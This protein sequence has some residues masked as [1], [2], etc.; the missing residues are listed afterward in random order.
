[1]ANRLGVGPATMSRWHRR[2]VLPA[3]DLRIGTLELWM[4]ETVRQWGKQRSRFR[5]RPTRPVPTPD[6][7]DATGVADRLAV[8]ARTIENWIRTG[9]FPRPDYRWGTIEAWLWETVEAWSR[10][11]LPQLP[12]VP[13]PHAAS[14]PTLA[15][16][17]VTV[18]PSRSRDPVG[19]I[20][21]IHRY[22]A[23]LASSLTAR[24]SD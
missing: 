22:F 6:I 14:G 9:T 4:W 10:T 11:S 21:R 18:A 7:V 20:E 23:E 12:Q 1:M 5:K 13:A 16:T 17:E 19:E 15:A 2:S 3:P 24:G 8:D